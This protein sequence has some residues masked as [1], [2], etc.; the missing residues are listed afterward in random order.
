MGNLNELE[1]VMRD[2]KDMPIRYGRLFTGSEK[3]GLRKIR[4]YAQKYEKNIK[5]LKDA[6]TEVNEKKI[7]KLIGSMID[8][9]T[10][11]CYKNQIAE[12]SLIKRFNKIGRL[13]LK[14]KVDSNEINKFIDVGM[15]LKQ[16]AYKNWEMSK[17]YLSRKRVSLKMAFKELRK[18]ERIAMEIEEGRRYAANY[19]KAQRFV[20][21]SIIKLIEKI[22]KDE[23]IKREFEDNLKTFN[24]SVNLEMTGIYSIM[25][26]TFLLFIDLRKKLEDLKNQGYS[27]THYNLLVKEIDDSGDKLTEMAEIPSRMAGNLMA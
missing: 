24:S 2:R 11:L 18:P 5:L 22:N 16:I 6:I 12:M 26:N 1:R 20:Q 25:S 17:A 19:V 3:R 21:R 4:K 14:F 7:T 10:T 15:K 27:E 23:K 8:D 9:L 13:L